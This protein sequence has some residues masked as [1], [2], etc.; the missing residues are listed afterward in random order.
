MNKNDIVIIAAKRTPIGSFQGA[1][2]SLSATQLGSCA[3]RAVLDEISIEP[4]AIDE[5][6]MGC[7][8]QAGLGQAPARQAARGAGIPDSVGCTTINKVCGSGMKAIMLG[9]DML[10][11]GSADLILA[12]G[13]ESMSNA[14]YL[15]PGARAGY[16]MGH[17]EL[18]DHM[19]HDG[20]QNVDDGEVMGYFAE[21]CVDRYQFTREA[22]D[23]YATASVQR[24]LEAV[25]SGAFR[26]EICTVTTS[27]KSGLRQ[28]SEDEEPQRCK[29][30]KI[31]DLK[32]VFRAEGG[33]V[34]A[35]SSAAISDG[36]AALILTRA[37]IADELDIKPLVRIIAQSS[38]ANRPEDFTTAPIP[39]IQKLYE[40]T[41]WSDTDVDL[42][43]IN[44]AFAA[45]VM[46]AMRDLELD[47]AKVNVNGGACALGHPIGATGARLV[48]TL[49]H[50]LHQRRLKRGMAALCIGGGEATA[51]ALEID[52]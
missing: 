14:P 46:A 49:R 19:N 13:M 31:A 22:Q 24:A 34:T 30:E 3:I 36:A 11:A 50:A 37:E 45:V 8:L 9:H 51:L 47:R 41:G 38:H 12:G 15:L 7:V 43:E 27:G 17:R 29:P 1:L 28:V 2:A 35:A 23:A 33:T 42:Y 32:P 21:R 40:K 18:L 44:E 6:F 5:V 39:A 26:D 52:T 16:R 4:A 25:Q 10:C 20:L 48:V